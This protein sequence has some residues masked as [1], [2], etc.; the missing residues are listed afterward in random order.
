M[1]GEWISKLVKERF[2]NLEKMHRVKCPTLLIHGSEDT[3]IS[4]SHSEKLLQQC[5]GIT[6][7]KVQ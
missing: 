1:A 2:R 6:Q 7:L 5:Q 4:V 3:L